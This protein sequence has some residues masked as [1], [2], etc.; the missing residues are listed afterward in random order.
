MDDYVKL[1]IIFVILAMVF[2]M[3]YRKTKLK[4]KLLSI[5]LL[6]LFMDLMVA[7]IIPSPFEWITF[8]IFIILMFLILFN[9]FTLDIINNNVDQIYADKEPQIWDDFDTPPELNVQNNGK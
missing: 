7:M 2:L 8:L 9:K 6:I 3:T 1:G 5:Y 4:Y